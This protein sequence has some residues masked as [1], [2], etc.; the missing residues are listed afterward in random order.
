MPD[1]PTR[2]VGADTRT[3]QLAYIAGR[4]RGIPVADIPRWARDELGVALS[5]RRIQAATAPIR[6][7]SPYK[8]RPG[9]PQASPPP[10]TQKPI[11]RDSLIVDER[12]LGLLRI[13][14]RLPNDGLPQPGLLAALDGLTGVRQILEVD[15]TREILIVA[16]VRSFSEADDLRARLEELAPGRSVQRDLVSFESTAAAPATWRRLAQAVAHERDEL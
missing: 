12:R 13:L 11:I 14:F 9:R 2:R 3:A 5:A 10:R 16:V 6:A 7:T 1:G 15:A 8:R 4:M